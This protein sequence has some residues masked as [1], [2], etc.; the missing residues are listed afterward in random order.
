MRNILFG[1]SLC[2]LLFLGCWFISAVPGL[3]QVYFGVPRV[4]TSGIVL[5]VVLL[6]IACVYYWTA[7]RRG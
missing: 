6:A 5:G 3:V 4:V 7:P 2:V 1:L